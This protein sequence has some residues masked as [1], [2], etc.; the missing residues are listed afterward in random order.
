MRTGLGRLWAL[1]RLCAEGRSRPLFRSR[2][3]F[4]T[5]SIRNR[6]RALTTLQQIFPPG[7]NYLIPHISVRDLISDHQ[8]PDHRIPLPIEEISDS[9]TVGIKQEAE[10]RLGREVRKKKELE[11]GQGSS[12]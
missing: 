1:P 8:G 3:G 10:R 7:P 11:S 9:I 4:V 6:A 5:I 2:N 12:G